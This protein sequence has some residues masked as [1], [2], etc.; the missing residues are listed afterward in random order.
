MVS[1]TAHSA[2][3]A[4][5]EDLPLMALMRSLVQKIWEDLLLLLSKR[6][7]LLDVGFLAVQEMF[8]APEQNAHSL[9]C[10]EKDGMGI[11]VDV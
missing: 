1:Q 4:T 8:F 9:T 7:L 10:T 6:D 11:I 5:S 3:D 2:L